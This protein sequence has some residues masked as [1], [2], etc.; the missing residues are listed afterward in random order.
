[1]KA[2]SIQKSRARTQIQFTQALFLLVGSRRSGHWAS[3]QATARRSMATDKG[4]RGVTPGICKPDYSQTCVRKTAPKIIC[5][6]TGDEKK[7]Y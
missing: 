6:A 4:I 3:K 7:Y 2:I 5:T 1:M